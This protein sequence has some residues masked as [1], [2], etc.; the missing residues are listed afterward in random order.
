MK[1]ETFLDQYLSV[2]QKS[3]NINIHRLSVPAMT[4][5]V[6]GIIKAMPVPESW[7]LWLDWSAFFLLAAF[8]F[9]SF[10]KNLK[11]LAFMLLFFIPQIVL[12]EYLRPRFFLL[13]VFLVILSLILQFIG[14]KS[15]H[16]AQS[17]KDR[18]IFFIIAPAALMKAFIFPEKFRNE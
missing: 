17:M 5:G 13:S 16:K 12:L 14:H 11:L 7:P 10:F 3:M 2:H 8:I 9:Y 18:F 6:L 15:E 4:F 1:L